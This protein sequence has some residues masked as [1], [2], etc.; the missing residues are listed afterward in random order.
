MTSRPLTLVLVTLAVAGLLLAS[1]PAAL[2]ND[3]DPKGC[4]AGA[5]AAFRGF[6]SGSVT[7]QT[8]NNAFTFE[9]PRGSSEAVAISLTGVV[10]VEVEH[11]CIESYTMQVTK[12]TQLGSSVVYTAVMNPG[13]GSGVDVHHVPVGLDA[14]SYEFVL[15][16]VGCDGTTGSDA[17]KLLILDPPT[18][19][20]GL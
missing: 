6:S 12:H 19:D 18:P 11:R 16:W 4:E 14:G 2:A 20:V 1:A 9:V 8:P 17:R 7:L 3:R 5:F 10:D 15:K 13:C